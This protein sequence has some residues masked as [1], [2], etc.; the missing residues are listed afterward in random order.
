MSPVGPSASYLGCTPLTPRADCSNPG[1]HHQLRLAVV[2]GAA[3]VA[4][5]ALYR[6][7]LAG[8]RGRHPGCQDVRATDRAGVLRRLSG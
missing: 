4:G 5:L 6:R 2:P 1:H 8:Q 3:I 7:C